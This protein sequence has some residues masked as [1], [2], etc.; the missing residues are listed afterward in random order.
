MTI[1]A[2]NRRAELARLALPAMFGGMFSTCMTA[3]IAALL[4]S[5]T[6]IFGATP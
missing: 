5:S 2:P 1:L 6:G 3:C 4:T